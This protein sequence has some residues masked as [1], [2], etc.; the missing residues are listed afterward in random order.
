MIHKMSSLLLKFQCSM[1]FFDT[2]NRT[3]TFP[4]DFT[5]T[6]RRLAMRKLL[7]SI[8][9]IDKIED[10]YYDTRKSLLFVEIKSIT[11]ISAQQI[12]NLVARITKHHGDEISPD[13]K[14]L[15]DFSKINMTMITGYSL[16]LNLVNVYSEVD[17]KKL[18]AP[19]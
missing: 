17:M 8:I 18:P 12:S 2:Q 14:T 13:L 6:T 7:E 5:D 4:L 19:I 16:N 15:Y 9:Q 3:N 10:F 11:V 1:S